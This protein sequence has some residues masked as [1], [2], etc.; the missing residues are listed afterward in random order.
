MKHKIS[1]NLSNLAG[2]VLLAA[3]VMAAAPRLQAQ[4]NARPARSVSTAT[5]AQVVNQLLNMVEHDIVPLAEA[6]P[7]DKYDF[8]PTNGDFKGVRTF[9]DQVKH[10]VRAN[11]YMFGAAASMKPRTC[12]I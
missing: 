3:A 6:M 1:G 11:Y 2:A 9:G 5:P 4:S 7:A 12:R 10:L 8:A